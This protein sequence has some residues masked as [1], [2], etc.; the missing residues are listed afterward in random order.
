MKCAVCEEAQAVI[1]YSS[2]MQYGR[3]WMEGR[4]MGGLDVTKRCSD[5]AAPKKLLGNLSKALAW[6][7]LSS[8]ADAPTPPTPPG[9]LLFINYVSMEIFVLAS[10]T[11]P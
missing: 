8:S 4:E 7:V 11:E 6:P 3:E 9:L 2:S 10:P 5:A 1:R